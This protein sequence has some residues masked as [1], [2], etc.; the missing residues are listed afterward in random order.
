MSHCYSI[1]HQRTSCKKV[2]SSRNR[3]HTNLRVFLKSTLIL[4]LT[5]WLSLQRASSCCPYLQRI[6]PAPSAS[7]FQSQAWGIQPWHD[8][9]PNVL[10]SNFHAQCL[11]NTR[12]ELAA[13]RGLL[14]LTPSCHQ[15]PTPS[16]VPLATV[17][18][19]DAHL[20]PG[21]GW[22]RAWSTPAF[23]Q[24]RLFPIKVLF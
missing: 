1:I 14:G 23:W 13:R 3:H 8:P 12:S 18:L 15:C 4:L 19:G 16:A 2:L 5:A 24:G 7:A 20:S 10:P 17:S 6:A 22:G 9:W 21:L 11:P